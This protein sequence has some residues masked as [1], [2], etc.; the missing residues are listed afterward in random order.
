MERLELPFF[1]TMMNVWLFEQV[2]NTAEIKKALIQAS[3]TNDEAEQSRLD[4]AFID[5]SM[6]KINS[7]GHSRPE[8]VAYSS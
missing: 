6:T 8:H 3:Q 5:A 1:S 2:K 7:S 4:W